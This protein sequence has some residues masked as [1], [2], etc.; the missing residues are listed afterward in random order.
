VSLRLRQEIQAVLR[1]GD[2]GRGS[3]LSALLTSLLL[4]VWAN[5]YDSLRVFLTLCGLPL[6]L[7]SESA[8]AVFACVYGAFLICWL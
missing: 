7:R 1:R 5:I 8:I 4:P 3:P 6:I 2:G